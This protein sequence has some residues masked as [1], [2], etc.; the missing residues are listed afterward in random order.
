MDLDSFPNDIVSLSHKTPTVV[1]L[2]SKRAKQQIS[3]CAVVKDAPCA[4]VPSRLCLLKLSKFSD[5]YEHTGHRE[6]P[7][8]LDVA[9]VTELN[10]FSPARAQVC[11]ASIEDRLE[12][13][14]I[15]A[16]LA[17]RHLFWRCLNLWD[18]GQRVQINFVIQQSKIIAGEQIS[19]RRGRLWL[20]QET[21]LVM[22]QQGFAMLIVL[23]QRLQPS[24]K[25]EL[26]D[27]SRIRHWGPTA[28]IDELVDFQKSRD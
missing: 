22:L 28:G 4:P 19:D 13:L 5:K 7:T 27:I 6:K 20:L 15:F 16:R 1:Q 8:R 11:V 24:R 9:G 10:Q 26:A 21:V 17:L 25:L 3:L 2:P 14:E 23:R 18:M 12:R